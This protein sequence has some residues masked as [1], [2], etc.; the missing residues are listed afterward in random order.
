MKRTRHT[1]DQIVTKL[2]EADAMLAAAWRREYNCHRPH[3]SLGYIPRGVRGGSYPSTKTLINIGTENGGRT[4]GTP[5][6]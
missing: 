2:H 3:S 4:A 5:W 1:P 6:K